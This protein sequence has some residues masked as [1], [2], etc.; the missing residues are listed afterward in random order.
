MGKVSPSGETASELENLPEPFSGGHYAFPF[1][2][3]PATS[4]PL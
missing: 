1:R 4:E 2:N 3:T